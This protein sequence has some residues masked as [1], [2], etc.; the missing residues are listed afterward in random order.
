[1]RFHLPALPDRAVTVENS[2]CAYSNKIR[3]FRT[4]MRARG[5]E[6][7]VYGGEGADVECYPEDAELTWV[8]EEW[9]PYNDAAAKEI[10]ERAESGDFLCLIAG[11]AQQSLAEQVQGTGEVHDI[12]AVEFG[13]GYT[14]TFSQFRVFESY[15]WMHAVYGHQAPEPMS[16]PGKAYDAVIPNYFDPE[17]FPFQEEKGGYLLFV[18]RMIPMKGVEIASQLAK[19][20]DCQLILAGHETETV[21]DYGDYIGPV[22]VEARGELMAG[23]RAVLAPTL[24]I[25]PFGG[26]VVE[27]H[28]CG[29]PTLVNDWGAMTETVIPGF[30]GWRCRTFGDYLWAA[31]HL[32][33]LDPQKIRDHA[34]ATYSTATIAEVYERYFENVER[35]WHGIGWPDPRPTVPIGYFP[36]ALEPQARP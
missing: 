19:E 10:L 34:V 35:V 32:D 24:Y 25:E 36:G 1:M 11:R 16:A 2:T 8:P 28:L 20:L 33:Q 18:G 7:T 13:I 14:G 15:A 22:G 9:A 23:A 27:A 31:E 30:N 6:V 5:H 12:L 29:T 21:P 4:M 17:E 3:R 26:V